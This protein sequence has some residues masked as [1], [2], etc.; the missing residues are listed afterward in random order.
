MEQSDKTFEAGEQQ[1]KMINDFL[2]GN[3]SVTDVPDSA[4]NMIKEQGNVVDSAKEMGKAAHNS[5]ATP[6]PKS[7][8]DLADLGKGTIIVESTNMVSDKKEMN[9]DER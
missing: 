4:E 7:A 6:L 9:E 3:A 2:K 8:D 1:S 5:F